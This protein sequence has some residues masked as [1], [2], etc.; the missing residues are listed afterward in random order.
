M[1]P[2]ERFGEIRMVRIATFWMVISCSV[3]LSQQLPKAYAFSTPWMAVVFV[4]PDC[5]ISQKYMRRLNE[6]QRTYHQQ[7]TFLAVVPGKVAKADVK[8][9]AKEYR[10]LLSFEQDENLEW[11][12]SLQASVTPEVFLVGADRQLVYSGAIDNW[13]YELGKSRRKVTESYLENAIR[14]VMKNEKPLIA[15]TEAIGCFIQ[16]PAEHPHH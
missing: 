11:V 12:Q 7:V 1:D 9:F 5:P 16:Q 13:F 2:T 14:S 3:A 10:S 8:K 6:L 15:R 4:S